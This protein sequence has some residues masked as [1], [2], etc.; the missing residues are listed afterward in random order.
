MQD[1]LDILLKDNVKSRLLDIGQQNTYKT[2]MGPKIRAQIEMYGY[3][4][5]VLK[6][7]QL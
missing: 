7:N 2:Q 5:K 4:R 3:L 6:K 1:Q